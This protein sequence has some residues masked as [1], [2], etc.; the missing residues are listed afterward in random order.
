MVKRRQTFRTFFAA[1]CAVVAASVTLASCNSGSQPIQPLSITSGKPPNG[2]VGTRFNFPLAATGGD[3]GY[4][5]GWSAVASSM[6][7]PGLTL[8]NLPLTPPGQGCQSSVG[9]V[10]TT[11]GS[12]NV[13][14]TVRDGESPAQQ[15]SATYTITIAP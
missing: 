12:Y 2:I 4:C 10:P 1:A 11:A 9:G 13:V 8:I 7:P 15:A 3:G 14:L 5:W 6:L